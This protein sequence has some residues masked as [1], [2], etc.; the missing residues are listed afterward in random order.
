[1]LL[2]QKNFN[3]FPY[4]IIMMY[5]HTQFWLLIFIVAIFMSIFSFF[6]Y[7]REQLEII[8][9]ILLFIVTFLLFSFSFLTVSI[10]S[11]ELKIKF[12]YWIIIKSFNIGDIISV[13]RVKNKWYTWWWIR[14]HINPFTT[15]YNV[16]WFDAVEIITKEWKIFRIWTDEVIELEKAI[17]KVIANK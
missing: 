11:N 7:V 15:I 9:V 17:T 8:V 5:K 14:Y 3:L 13:K 4:F 10:D 12:W 1:M 6:L 2:S 16:S